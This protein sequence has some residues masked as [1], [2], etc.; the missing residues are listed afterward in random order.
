[1]KRSI[2]LCSLILTLVYIPWMAVAGTPVKVEVLYMNHGPL[3]DSL[4]GIKIQGE[5]CRFLV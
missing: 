1:M 3:Q 2:L 5:S 4:E